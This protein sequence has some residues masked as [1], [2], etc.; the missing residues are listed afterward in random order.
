MGDKNAAHLD[1]P[2]PIP[3]DKNINTDCFE[4]NI[5]NTNNDMNKTSPARE[6]RAWFQT[7][8]TGE[9]KAMSSCIVDDKFVGM[10][11]KLGI[12]SK[13]ANLASQGKKQNREQL[14]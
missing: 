7:L 4:K 9:S 5:E 1:P 11:L 6:A 12:D 8:P 14:I 10:L 2:I 13:E 3:E